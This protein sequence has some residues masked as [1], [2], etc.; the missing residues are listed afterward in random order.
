[1]PA[2]MWH[3]R[4][5]VQGCVWVSVLALLMMVAQVPPVVQQLESLIHYVPLNIIFEMFAFAVAMMIFGMAWVTQRYRPSLQ[6]L[7]I[8]AGFL[9][10]AL[11][12]L[13]HLLSYRVMPA[14]ITDNTP[15]KAINFWLAAR[16]LTAI[17]LLLMAFV[18]SL[19]SRT[20]TRWQRRCGLM[21]VLSVVA[22][23][24][25]WFIGFPG[26]VPDTFV[27]GEGLT[28]FK[29]QF[30]YGMIAA[31]LLAA[32]GLLQGYRRSGQ[33][34]YLYL[35]VSAIIMAMAEYFLTR[36]VEFTDAFNILGHGYKIIS[37][38]FLYRALFRETVYEPYQSLSD[39]R[40]RLQ[41]TLNALPDALLEVDDN[42][43]VLSVYATGDA[44]DLPAGSEQQDWLP[45]QAGNAFFHALQEA[46]KYGIAHHT[47]MALSSGEHLE[48][49]V[50]RKRNQSRRSFLVM[51]R[52]VTRQVA[53]EQR[54]QHETR[55]NNAL[56]LVNHLDHKASVA[57]LLF[58]C[59]KEAAELSVSTAAVIHVCREHDAEYLPVDAV[60]FGISPADL[61][62]DSSPWQTAAARHNTV[63]WHDAED[64]PYSSLAA[65]G[66]S[67]PV[68]DKGHV[69]LVL[70][71][72]GKR[73]YH[74]QDADSLQILA[75]SI[76]SRVRQRRQDGV[77]HLL[78]KALEQSPYPVIIT[79]ADVRLQYVN[80][81]FM[82]VSGF[83][84]A[85]VIGRNPK[86]FKSGKTAHSV[87]QDMWSTL[88]RGHTWKGELINRRRQGDEYTESTT[89]YPVTDELGRVIHYVAHKEDI[90]EQKH[91]AE[92]LREL[93]RFDQLTGLLNKQAFEQQLALQMKTAASM[94]QGLALMWLDIDNFKAVNDTLGHATGDEILVEM[95]N[96]LQEELA[97]GSLVGRPEGDSVVLTVKN[98]EHKSLALLAERL[99]A[100]IEQPVPT[101]GT[102]LS[103]SASLGIATFPEDGNSAQHLFQA[104][105]LAMYRVKQDGRNGLRFY[106]PDM[107]KN[108]ERALSLA[109]ALKNAMVNGELALAFQPQLDLQQGSVTGAEALLR[110]QHPEWGFVSPGE[111][112]PLAEQNGLIVNIGWWIVDRVL[113]QLNR[114]QQ[115]GFE[116]IVIAINV[117]AV[118]LAQPD[119]VARL[120]QRVAASG[121]PASRLELELTETVAML[122]PE[123]TGEQLATL[124]AAG[125]R[126][127]IDD[128]GTGYSSMSY[129]K[130][131]SVNKLK[132]DKSF[133]DD[134]TD[135]HE[136]KAIVN[137]I[138]QMAK[139]LGMSTIAEGVET[140]A[141]LTRLRNKGC[142]AIQGYWFSRPLFEADFHAFIKS[143]H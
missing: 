18:P 31:C 121:V 107:Q 35:T 59:A 95:A 130:R 100:R 3:N 43:R 106:A 83:S 135:N 53:N 50:S 73:R 97:P 122:N 39:A 124:S 4:E 128:F 51:S 126:I 127:S 113:E 102:S 52:N 29:I 40:S 98:S 101:A 64:T 108:S 36:Y 109:T 103:L 17:T 80:P 96:R 27:V 71:V 13:S 134:I 118:Q 65:T 133:I 5:V 32:L 116:N 78:S 58:T 77:I 75:D 72:L 23:C 86:M 12:D 1:M 76:W 66:M 104:A 37:Y 62:Q 137:A 129:L 63:Q 92:R 117:S 140:E 79:D 48:L 8:G 84:A 115:S 93:S 47:R 74:R 119:F 15:E 105:E 120:Q 57:E 28:P 46:D 45:A 34:G 69:P 91:N 20:T 111:F 44:G 49:S 33:L 87:Y 99:L 14:F 114:L 143:R 85:E 94:G 131:F 110:W 55:L 81:A 6:A 25:V 16:A 38:G 89:I 67:V 54:I 138:I 82:A 141:Q 24:Q 125:F 56:S 22:L 30:E 26:T 68:I 90:T 60:P 11:L 88:G 10:V 7:V 123:H 132:I 41:A 112:I 142:D 70:T 42:G 2:G 9:G 21:F 136:D 61:E 139:S 19:S